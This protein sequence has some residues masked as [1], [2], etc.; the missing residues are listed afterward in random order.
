MHWYVDPVVFWLE[1]IFD[2]ACL[3]RG[4][5]DVAYLTE[6]DPMWQRRRAD[7]HPQSRRSRCSATSPPR[8]VCRR[9][10]SGH[11]RLPRSTLCSGAGCQGSLYPAEWQRAGPYRWRPGIEVWK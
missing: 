8:R 10:R 4:G 11:C 2:N 3:E 1:A 6:L 9:L 5:F 7:L